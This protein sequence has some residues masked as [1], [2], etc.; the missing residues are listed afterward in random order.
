MINIVDPAE[1]GLSAER[2]ER[3][4]RHLNGYVDSGRLPFASVLVSRYGQPAYLHSYGKM[5]VE[6]DKSVQEDTIVRIYSMSKPITSVAAMML[7]EEAKFQLGEAVSNYIPSLANPDVFIG[8]DADNP[9]TVP[10]ERDYSIREIFTHTGGLTY[11][12]DRGGVVDEMYQKNKIK[13]GNTDY[14]LDEFCRRL[15][16]MPLIAQPGSTW[17]YSMSTDVLGHLVEV[18]SGENLDDFMRKRIFEPL[19]MEDTFFTVPSDKKDRF[20]ACYIPHRDGGLKLQDAPGTSR[21]TEPTNILSGGGGLMSTIGDYYKFAQ[22]MANGG[23]LEGVRLLSPRTVDYMTRNHLPG[24]CDMAAMGQSVFSEVS[25]D[26][27]GF[28]LGVHVVLDPAAAAYH[29]MAGE[30]GWGGMASTVWWNNPEEDMSLVFV[31][32]LMPSSTYQIRPE[33]R[34]LVHSAIVD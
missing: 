22:M 16:E 4:G 13:T 17:N 32:Q 9:Q 29:T 11:G 2:L 5:D 21:F 14:G 20:A 34:N 12:F 26:G 31:T 19:G 28:G 33:M 1:V 30:Y 15:G 18:I 23:E 7:Y 3:L 27:V 25:Y 8:G 6:A 24:N 10:A